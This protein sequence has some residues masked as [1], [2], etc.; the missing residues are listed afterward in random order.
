MD[1]R[2]E[3]EMEN[4]KDP[5]RKAVLLDEMGFLYVKDKKM[6]QAEACFNNAI[7]YNPKDAT[8]VTNL[9]FVMYAKGEGKKARE[10]FK[11]ATVL[12][13]QQ[14]D[15]WGN[16]ISSYLSTDEVDLALE[17][18]EKARENNAVSPYIDANE[19]CALIRKKDP[20]VEDKIS[21]ICKKYPEMKKYIDND[22]DV[23]RYRRNK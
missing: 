20:S 19:I 1:R 5:V 2:L 10:L 23:I 9:G 8:A 21:V 13:P 4:T 17:A 16:L 12:D 18:V 3:D 22:E 15:A 11:K 6:F 7:S 14:Y